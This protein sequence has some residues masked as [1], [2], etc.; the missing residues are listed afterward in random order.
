MFNY[1]FRNVFK[2][3]KSSST[4]D[5]SIKYES[6]K[7]NAKHLFAFNKI[8]SKL[9]C[10]N[11]AYVLG[12]SSFE[13]FDFEIECNDLTLYGPSGDGKSLFLVE[14]KRFLSFYNCI[15][16]RKTAEIPL[17]IETKRVDFSEDFLILAMK[18]MRII[19]YFIADES[20]PEESYAKIR[21]LE[22]RLV[23]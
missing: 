2:L 9:V 12:R 15:E 23:F 4:T 3:V 16:W 8:K 17:Y 20:R 21:K 19:S 22:S 14:N 13:K 7:L 1:N 6:F 5:K 11:I 10:F 18:D